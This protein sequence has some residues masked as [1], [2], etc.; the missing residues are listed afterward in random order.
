[1]TALLIGMIIQSPIGEAKCAFCH[2]PNGRKRT[3]SCSV[4]SVWRRNEIEPDGQA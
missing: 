3:S 1:M 4:G 2:R